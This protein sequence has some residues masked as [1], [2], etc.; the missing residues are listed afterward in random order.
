[1]CKPDSTAAGVPAGGEIALTSYRDASSEIYVMNAD[2]SGVTR[3][4]YNSALGE[5]AVWSPDGE[6]I[7][8]MSTRDGNL[9]IYLMH[10]DG[11]GLAHL[12]KN[13]AQRMERVWYVERSKTQL[14]T[15][16]TC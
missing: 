2:G 16:S 12:T 9:E 15:D 3:L 14:H 10:A 4:T 7:A 6:K 8:F 11:T 13:A 1:A 5:G